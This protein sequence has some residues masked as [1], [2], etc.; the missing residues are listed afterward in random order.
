VLY[1]QGVQSEPLG[2]DSNYY[3]TELINEWPKLYNLKS[4]NSTINENIVYT[5]DFYKEVVK[6]PS[7]ID[8]FLDFIKL[9]LLK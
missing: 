3:Y 4:K 2:T 5:G 9:Q 7:D 1:L 8:Y 6:T